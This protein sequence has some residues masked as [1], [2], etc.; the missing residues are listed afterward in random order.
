MKK[1]EALKKLAELAKT[2]T[3]ATGKYCSEGNNCAIGH[4]LKIG[5]LTEE[6]LKEID[7]GKYDN[8]YSIGSV[9]NEIKKYSLKLDNVKE[10]LTA[11]GF[12][13]D[14]EIDQALLQK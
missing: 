5:G 10:S 11:L 14:S 6:G 1:V 8:W 3:F 2:N 12:D 9:I 4:L 7:E 13:T